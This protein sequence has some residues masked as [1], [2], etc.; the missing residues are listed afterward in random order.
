MWYEQAGTEEAWD[1][2]PECS[3]DCLRG[4]LGREPTGEEVDQVLSRVF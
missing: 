2:L 4:L 3:E 1:M